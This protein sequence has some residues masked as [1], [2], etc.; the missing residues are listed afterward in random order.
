MIRNGKEVTRIHKTSIRI[1]QFLNF[2]HQITACGWYES[3]SWVLQVLHVLNVLHCNSW[4]TV[5]TDSRW[6]TA[7]CL[8]DPG[9]SPVPNLEAPTLAVYNWHGQCCGPLSHLKCGGPGGLKST[10]FSPKRSMAVRLGLA[11]RSSKAEDV[12]LSYSWTFNWTICMCNFKILYVTIVCVCI[13]YTYNHT[14]SC[15]NNNDMLCI[16]T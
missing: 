2:Y 12:A 9:S 8:W 14:Y 16:H 13:I 11:R 1:K 5:T 6:Q 15:K 7:I 4:T 10:M 3:N